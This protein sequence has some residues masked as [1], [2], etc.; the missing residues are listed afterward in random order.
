MLV[1]CLINELCSGEHD[2][3]HVCTNKS[4]ENVNCFVEMGKWYCKWL[5]INA[6]KRMLTVMFE[7]GIDWYTNKGQYNNTANEMIYNG[8][9][10]RSLVG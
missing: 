8:I 5:I 4:V 6:L 2:G 3:I 9:P 10:I 1:N 7:L